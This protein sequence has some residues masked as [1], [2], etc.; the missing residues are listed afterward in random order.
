MSGYKL[1]GANGDVIVFDNTNYVLTPTLNG[2]G[3][4]PTSVRIDDS[5]RDGGV[6]RNSRKTV[7]NIDMPVVVLGD[8]ATD[9]E[10]KLRRLSRLVQDQLGPTTLTAMRFDEDDNPDDLE[11]R[12]HYT[13]GAE[14]SY[15]E[16][17][18]GKQF[19]KLVLSFQAPQPYW[20]SAV[21]ES[22]TVT[23]GNTGRGLLPEL[24]KLKLS[25][26]QALGVIQVD[27]TSDVPVFPVYEVRGPV[28]NLRVSSGSLSWEI[29][30]PILEGDSL[31][32]DTEAGT[33]T[34]I[35]GVNRYS[36]LKPA[37]KLFPFQPGQSTITV[38][39]IDANINT[40]ITCSYNLRF[41]VVHG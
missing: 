1:T 15:G 23:S 7:R 27:N 8:S 32:V 17:S 9:V 10:A 6:F 26:S 34:G 39:G 37:P 31:T 36:L 21:S 4:P 3:I 19:A 33:V 41:E 16:S 25:S 40:L 20:E 12:L 24:S 38:E 35:G 18:G 30:G 14:L 13:G 11:M 5:S 28:T 22:F 29:D 2:F